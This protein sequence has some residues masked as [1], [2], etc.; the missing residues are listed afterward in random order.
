MLVTRI[1]GNCP[2]Y[3][4]QNCFGNVSIH[5]NNLLRGCT[6]CQYTTLIPLPNIKKKVIYLD[7]FFFSGAFKSG[8]A[9]FIEAANRI[10]ELSDKLLIVAPYSSIHEDET[11]QWRG[12]NEKNKEGLMDFIKATSRG[13]KFN[14][15]Y[16]VERVQVIKAFKA[17]LEKDT[18][19]F[20]FK[21]LDVI[22]SNI[23]KWD[24]YFRID[25][26]QYIKDI[27]FIRELKTQSIVELVNTFK[28]WKESKNT[29]KD[30][31][32]LEIRDAAKSYINSYFDYITRIANGDYDAVLDSPIIS[33][34]MELMLHHLPHDM[35]QEEKLKKRDRFSKTRMHSTKREK[36]KSAFF[37]ACPERAKDHPRPIKKS[38]IWLSTF[39]G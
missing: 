1:L 34:V 9:R 16:V 23:H 29:L 27:D 5:D 11:Y 14:S 28:E 24:N 3:A 22:N 18:S 19:I 36:K 17:F 12:Y 26:G 25:V 7:Q 37:R 4:R 30:D 35:S 2:S 31:I 32:E 38:A 13:H 10:Q 15:Q 6:H 8:E 33:Q 20:S 21:E 39:L